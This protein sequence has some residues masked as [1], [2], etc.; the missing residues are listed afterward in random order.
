MKQTKTKKSLI[1][2]TKH[3]LSNIFLFIVFFFGCGNFYWSDELNIFSDDSVFYQCI[4]NMSYELKL[5]RS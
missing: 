5:K 4:S 3:T 1:F 2:N